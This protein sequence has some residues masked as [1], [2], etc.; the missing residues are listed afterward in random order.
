M[1]CVYTDGSGFQKWF[2]T[3]E[4]AKSYALYVVQ[5][6]GEFD[7]IHIG[8][9]YDCWGHVDHDGYHVHEDIF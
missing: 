7:R 3:F 9:E 1:F 6:T 2:E 4:E 5:T 8:D